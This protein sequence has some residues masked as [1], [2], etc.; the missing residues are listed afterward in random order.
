M[1]KEEYES[2]L[3]RIEKEFN[4]SPLDLHNLYDLLRHC[5]DTKMVKA[6]RLDEWYTDFFRDLELTVVPEIKCVNKGKWVQSRV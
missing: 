2:E 4:F 1:N 6:T 5:V 3:K